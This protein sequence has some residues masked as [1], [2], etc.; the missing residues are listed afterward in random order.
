MNTMY[1][2]ALRSIAFVVLPLAS[3]VHAQA[4]ALLGEKTLE[5]SDEELVPVVFQG[6]VFSPDGSP[7]EGAVVVTSAGGQ[8]GVDARGFYR[9]EARVPRGAESVRVTAVGNA[10]R[11]LV[12]SASVGVTSPGTLDIDPLALTAGSACAPSWIPTFGGVLGTDGDV[13]ALAV[14]D[15][16]SGPALYVGG[17][18]TMAGGVAA[19][20]IA[21]WDGSNWSELGSGI[22][23]TFFY[24]AALAVYDD[25]D[26]PALY[27]GGSFTTA[28]GGAAN[29]IARWD[30]TTWTPLGSGLDYEA[31]DLEVFDDGTGPQLFVA[32]LF[33]TA[34][35][36]AANNIA[37]WDGSSWSALGAG[38]DGAV[39]D[40]A[41]YDDGSGAA[42][43]AGGSFTTAGGGAANRIA[44]WDGSS[45]SALG[46]GI[47]GTNDYVFALT[48]YDDGSGTSLYA[49]GSITT[50]G[51]VAAAGIARWDGSSWSA[52]GSGVGGAYEMAVYDDGN[53]S[54]L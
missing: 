24:V 10:G 51:G 33:S 32:G 4:D 2:H 31:Y 45:L 18:F 17:V 43:Y 30:G 13:L 53:G 54:A 14:Y 1:S 49:C 8:A 20:N 36:G 40:M 41:V 39:F 9:I 11:N 42:L 15:D 22:G 35:G 19:N 5:R 12:A 26:G 3:T 50:A 46:S 37:S 16:G 21:R 7:A 38:T 6:F 23:G 34:G 44:R 27:V 52:L 25:G 48:V 28:G 47:G 29:G